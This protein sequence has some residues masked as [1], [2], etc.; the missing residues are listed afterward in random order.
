MNDKE[1]RETLKAIKAQVK[2]KPENKG[3]SDEEIDRILL[4]GFFQAFCDGKMSRNDL[5]AITQALG[6]EV[7]EEFMNDPSPDPIDLK[8]K[9]N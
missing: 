5:A 8:N 3:K 1:L 2:A 6:Y 4:D 7:S 9:N